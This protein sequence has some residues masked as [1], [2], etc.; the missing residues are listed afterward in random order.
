MNKHSFEKVA[1]ALLPHLPSYQ[2]NKSRHVLYQTPVAN[3]FRGFLFDSSRF[4]AE[5]FYPH[6]FVQPLYIPED[7]YVLTF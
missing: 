7:G 2:Y 5:A 1:K 6:F 3:V 4:S